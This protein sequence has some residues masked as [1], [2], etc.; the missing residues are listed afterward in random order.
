MNHSYFVQTFPVREFWG[1]QPLKK[2]IIV[3]I[4]KI[5]S[6]AFNGKL[7]HKDFEQS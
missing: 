6:I 4:R 2:Y 1:G 5:L 7:V 3:T